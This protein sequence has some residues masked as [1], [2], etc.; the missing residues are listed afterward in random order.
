MERYRMEIGA[1][2]TRGK[3]SSILKQVEGG[4]EVII[5]RRGKKV[6]RLIPFQK[7]KGHLPSLNK[8]RSS[9]N[10]KGKTVSAMVIIGREEGRY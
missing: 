4:K 3:L 6:A 10:I 8:F 2:E 9:M 5:L 7:P 1:K